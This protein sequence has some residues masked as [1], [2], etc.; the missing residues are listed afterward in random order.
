MFMNVV[1]AL[2]SAQLW[3]PSDKALL[4]GQEKSEVVGNN[5]DGI[6]ANI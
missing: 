3:H 4:N 1:D 6:R 5:I 2:Q